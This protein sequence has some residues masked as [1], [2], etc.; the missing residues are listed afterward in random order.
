MIQLFALG[1]AL[2]KRMVTSRTKVPEPGAPTASLLFHPKPPRKV[3]LQQRAREALGPPE[4]TGVAAWPSVSQDGFLSGTDGT[5]RVLSASNSRWQKTPPCFSGSLGSVRSPFS[6]SL[7]STPLHMVVSLQC[8]LKSRPPSAWPAPLP[9]RWK[10]R[11]FGQARSSSYLATGTLVSVASMLSPL[12]VMLVLL[13]P[14]T[15][16]QPVI[17]LPTLCLSSPNVTSMLSAQSYL[18]I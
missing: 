11:A 16:G 18:T 14:G 12:R 8:S 10:S 9:H 7:A 15:L 1:P 4:A 6:T 5:Q 13:S 3:T 17:E 2:G